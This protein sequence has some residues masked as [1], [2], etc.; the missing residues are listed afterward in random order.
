MKLFDDNE[1][2]KG[3]VVDAVF[4]R[5]FVAPLPLMT[6]FRSELDLDDMMN[7]SLRAR[8]FRQFKSREFGV[9]ECDSL[10]RDSLQIARVL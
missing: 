7:C 2:V 9:F 6:G 8:Q 5:N 1:V 4:C 3:V 10:N